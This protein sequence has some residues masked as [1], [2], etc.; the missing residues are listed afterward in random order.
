MAEATSVEENPVF[1]LKDQLV[2]LL[3]PDFGLLDQ[4]HSNGIL[5]SRQL[6][7]V[8][9]S[10]A[11][12][13][14][15]ALCFRKRRTVYLRTARLLCVVC[16]I[17]WSSPTIILTSKNSSFPTQSIQFLTIQSVCGKLLTNY[18]IVN[19]HHHYLSLPQVLHSLTASYLCRLISNIFTSSPHSP[20]CTTEPSNKLIPLVLGPHL[21][22]LKYHSSQLSYQA[23]WI[24]SGPIPTWLLKECASVLTHTITNI[25]NLSLTSAQF[26]LILKEYVISSCLQKHRQTPTLQLPANLQTLSHIQNNRT[27]CKMSTYLS[28]CLLQAS[29][30]WNN[31]IV[32]TVIHDHIINAIGSQKLSCLCL[33]D[34]SAAFDTVVQNVLIT[35]LSSW[36]GIHS[37]VLNWFKAYYLW[38]RSLRAKC[39]KNFRIAHP[40]PAFA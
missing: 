1:R 32:Y 14:K 17:N 7:E 33:L 2:E 18:F 13:D 11:I 22:N 37:S 39:K 19:L 31:T 9:E 26:H 6:S 40:P 4:L 30:H 34:L 25:V 38:S 10:P 27:C 20:Y 5:S 24:D 15:P 28:V 8:Q 35:R 36:F 21:L 12:A 3:E 29:P 16:I 23:I